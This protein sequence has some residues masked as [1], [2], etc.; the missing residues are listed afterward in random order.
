MLKILLE[1]EERLRSLLAPGGD[2][3]RF[4]SG[5]K[6]WEEVAAGRKASGRVEA[7]ELSKLLAG[8]DLLE[9]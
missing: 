3:V 7:N 9:N 5:E 8:K 2:F 1:E 4:I 6:S